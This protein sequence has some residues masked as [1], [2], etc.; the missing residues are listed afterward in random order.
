MRIYGGINVD[1]TGL[2]ASI[3]GMHLQS[4]MLLRG[5]QNINGFNKVGYQKKDQVVSEFAEYF[6]VHA[7]SEVTCQEVGRLAQTFRPLDVAL[8]TKGYF[9]Y[10]TPYGV[11]LTRDGRFKLDKNGYILTQENQKVLSSTGA[12]IKLPFT[13]AAVEDIKI[14]LDG[15]V[16]VVDRST[17][18]VVT[19]GTLGVVTQEGRHAQEVSVRQG[20][21]ENSNVV[22]Q[23]EIFKMLPVRRNFE[24]NRELYLVQNDNLTKT[25][26]SLGSSS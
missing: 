19:A 13:P 20:F 17:N 4:E 12:P 11:E 10:S 24:A 2:G 7:L 23:E 21:T 15:V 5:N 3:R 25:I 1:E 8:S 18:K 22:L 6:G 16:K 26:Q 9:Q 14:G